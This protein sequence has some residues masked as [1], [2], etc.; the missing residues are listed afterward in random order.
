MNRNQFRP[1]GMMLLNTTPTLTY[2]VTSDI[3]G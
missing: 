3:V 1:I 2:P